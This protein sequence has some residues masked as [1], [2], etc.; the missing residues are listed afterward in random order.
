MRVDPIWWGEAVSELAG[1]MALPEY[2]YTGRWKHRKR[3]R[4]GAKAGDELRKFET[5]NWEAR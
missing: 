1:G 2:T 3:K 5:C 4:R